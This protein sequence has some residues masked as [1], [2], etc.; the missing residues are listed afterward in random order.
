MLFTEWVVFGVF[1]NRRFLR[2]VIEEAGK[3]NH[4]VVDEGGD[5]HDDEASSLHEGPASPGLTSVFGESVVDDQRGDPDE[6]GTEGFEDCTVDSR[7]LLGDNH[8]TDVEEENGEEVNDT[9]DEDGAVVEDLVERIV[10]VFVVI[11]IIARDEVEEGNEDKEAHE[12][13]PNTFHT[14]DNQ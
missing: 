4:L 13:T 10:C 5:E 1:V 8:T 14:N 12:A 11:M 6:E 9:G 2:R 3:T 7:E